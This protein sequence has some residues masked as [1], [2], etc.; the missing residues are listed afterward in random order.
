MATKKTEAVAKEIQVTLDLKTIQIP[1]VGIA[2]LIVSRFDEKSKAQ[3][4]ESGQT[5]L[6]QGGKKK[7]IIAPEEQYAKS[8]YYFEDGKT[9]GFPAVAFKA[10]MVTAAYRTY[11]RQM[12]V[13]R[14]AFH[15]MEIGRAHV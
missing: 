8:I 4:E 7:N 6:K 5:G 2:P 9:C 1:I 14:S 13:T 12:T 3:I 10:A 11:G 15:V